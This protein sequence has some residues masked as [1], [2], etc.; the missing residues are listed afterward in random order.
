MFCQNINMWCRNPKADQHLTQTFIW[1][2][3]I[4]YW[5]Q[6]VFKWIEDLKCFEPCIV[7]NLTFPCY[8]STI[9]FHMRNKNKVCK[10]QQLTLAASRDRKPKCERN[11]R[12]VWNS[13]QA[14]GGVHSGKRPSAS[15][16]HRCPAA[17]SSIICCS[18][19]RAR[20]ACS[21]AAPTSMSTDSRLGM[22]LSLHAH[23]H[24]HII[25]NNLSLQMY[26]HTNSA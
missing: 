25:P 17:I 4:V 24:T 1:N 15:L 10:C 11:S 9:K 21:V 12:A 13:W 8:I 5:Q 7:G 2:T 23:K 3:C 16:H 18:T 20:W 6:D 14:G 22:D 26:Q 19:N